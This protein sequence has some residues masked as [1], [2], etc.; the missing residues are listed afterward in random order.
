[1]LKYLSCLVLVIINI[2]ESLK[3]LRL[4][5]FELQKRSKSILSVTF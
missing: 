3:S 4:F 5:L 1:M 2:G